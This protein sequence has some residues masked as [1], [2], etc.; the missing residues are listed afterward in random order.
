M[1]MSGAEAAAMAAVQSWL[2]SRGVRVDRSGSGAL[3]FEAARDQCLVE[4]DSSG[5]VRCQFG[6]DL[7]ELRDL[8]AGSATEDL[9]ED[10]LVRAARY[11]LQTIAKPY[12]ARLTAG[13]FAEEYEVTA[14]HAVIGYA[15]PV[16]L[17]QPDQVAAV[18]ARCLEI[19]R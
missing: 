6:V 19:L 7:A 9:G 16:D 5:V 1:R 13:G 8:I 18:L 12:A 15:H 11:H 17:S 4:V 3:S 14:E 10:E 2:E